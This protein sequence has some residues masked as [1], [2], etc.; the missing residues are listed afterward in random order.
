MLCPQQILLNPDY[1]CQSWLGDPWPTGIAGLD[2]S[3]LLKSEWQTAEVLVTILSKAE[4]TCFLSWA[5]GVG[6]TEGWG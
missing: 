3:V 6:V 1:T 4:E 2:S 5:W